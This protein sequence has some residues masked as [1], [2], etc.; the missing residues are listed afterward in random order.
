M[1]E[2]HSLGKFVMVGATVLYV[3]P[4]A[5]LDMMNFE[6]CL[7]IDFCCLKMALCLQDHSS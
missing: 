6:F 2:M 7:N 4:N 1:H 5:L 3:C